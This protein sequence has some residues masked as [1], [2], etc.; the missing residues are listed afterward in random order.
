MALVGTGA[1]CNLVY[2]KPEAVSLLLEIGWLPLWSY[3]VKALS[4]DVLLTSDSLEDSEQ[5]KSI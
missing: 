4:Y 1:E 2:C 5:Y 3:T